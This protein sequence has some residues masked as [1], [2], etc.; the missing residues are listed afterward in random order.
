VM[1]NYPRNILEAGAKALAPYIGR[2]EPYVTLPPSAKAE[3]IRDVQRV[4]SAVDLAA[5]YAVQLQRS[6]A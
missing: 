3:L 4:L 1:A 6:Q 2:G 5:L